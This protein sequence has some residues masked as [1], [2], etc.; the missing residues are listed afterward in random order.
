MEEVK[1]LAHMAGKSKD[2]VA[3]VDNQGQL[4]AQSSSDEMA[5]NRHA[6]AKTIPRASAVVGSKKVGAMCS[7]KSVVV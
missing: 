5:S 6:K 2:F 3:T 4:R 7:S 1:T